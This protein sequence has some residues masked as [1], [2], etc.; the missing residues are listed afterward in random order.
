MAPRKG[1]ELRD[2]KGC[3]LLAGSPR[4]RLAGSLEMGYEMTKTR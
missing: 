2:G 3:S 4:R 1:S